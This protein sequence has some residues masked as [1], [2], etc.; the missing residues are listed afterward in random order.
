M[1]KR[2]H[3]KVSTPE[4]IKAS[5]IYDSQVYSWAALVMECPFSFH[6]IQGEPSQKKNY[7]DWRK[8]KNAQMLLVIPTLCAYAL[9]I[10]RFQGLAIILA[11]LTGIIYVYLEPV[12]RR[13]LGNLLLWL[14]LREDNAQ[15]LS[16]KTLYQIAEEL[17]RKYHS[18]SLVKLI[19][20]SDQFSRRIL[21]LLLLL[22]F[23][24]SPFAGDFSAI[25]YLFASYFITQTA[26]KSLWLK[27]AVQ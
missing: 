12:K 18:P 20:L 5:V 24:I 17:T 2:A 25:L 3:E 16:Q 27:R 21:L 19:N 23:L 1:L 26:L 10:F 7:Q 9:F 13:S 6:Q 8:I 4:A 11:I 22:L 14:L 15:N